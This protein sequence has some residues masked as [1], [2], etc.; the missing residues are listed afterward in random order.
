MATDVVKLIDRSG[1]HSK[2]AAGHNGKNGRFANIP[3]PGAPGVDI[4]VRLAYS[5]TY[6]NEV[7]V[8]ESHGSSFWTIAKDETMLLQTNGGNGGDGGRGENGEHGGPGT[9]GRDATSYRD[10][11]PGG[12]GGRGGDGGSGSNGADGGPGGNITVTVDNDD[13][14]LLL[15][16]SFRAKGGSGG[17]PGYHGAP[18]NGGPGGPG[19][20]IDGRIRIRVNNDGRDTLSTYQ[21]IYE[22][23]VLSFDITD[24]NQDGINEPGEHICVRNLLV[25]N[26]GL[27]PS[28]ATRSIHVQI[29]PTRYLEPVLSEPLQLPYGIGPGQ[30]VEVPGVLRALIRN[31]ADGEPVGSLSGV[32]DWVQLTGVFHE[33]LDRPI[34]GFCGQTPIHISYPLV[35]DPPIFLRSVAKGDRVNFSWTVRNESQ[36]TY[37][38]KTGRPCATMFGEIMP[39]QE[40]CF[41]LT[42][43]SQGLDQIDEIQPGST[44]N[45]EQE[46][47][48]NDK[49]VDFIYGHLKVDLQLCDP[50]TS[51]D[52]TVQEH[53]MQV[54]VSCPYQRTDNAGYLLV[55]NSETPSYA[56]LQTLGF[57]KNHLHAK[58]DVFNLSIYGS[59]YI[60]GSSD[61]V[62]SE[63]MGK[64]I[65]IFGNDYDHP[66]VGL[67][68]PWD[69]IDPWVATVLLKGGT[70]FHFPNVPDAALSKLQSWSKRVVFPAHRLRA[71]Q[72]TESV[73]D[74]N[75]LVRKLR[76][77]GVRPLEGSGLE[78]GASAGNGDMVHAFRVTKSR[79]DRR[80]EAASHVLAENMPLR[81]F[82]TAPD[83]TDANGEG[84]RERRVLVIEGVPR[85]ARLTATTAPF[86]ESTRSDQPTESVTDHDAF[87]LVSS[88]PFVVRARMLWN[89]VQ[90]DDD[91][92]IRCDALFAGVEAYAS[93]STKGDAEESP[94]V[95]RKTILSLTLSLQF[96]LCNE[97]Y[98]MM[99]TKSRFPD[100]VPTKKKLLQM[101]LLSHFFDSA[102][103]DDVRQIQDIKKAQPLVFVLGAIHAVSNPI[104]SWHSFKA[105][106]DFLN[107]HQGHLKSRVNHFI[108]GIIQR[109]CAPS[110]V[111]TV[112][113]H[114]MA[115]S[116]QVRQGIRSQPSE[117]H[118][119]FHWFGN[120]ELAELTGDE[121]GGG[122]VAG[123]WGWIDLLNSGK[124]GLALTGQACQQW[125]DYHET[126][127]KAQ[128]DVIE[129]SRKHIGS[130]VNPQH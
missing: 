125:V 122:T 128:A 102:P 60:R 64:S 110:I 55:V 103:R 66:G 129:A 10:G 36:K 96:D 74:T 25:K 12:P 87:L 112:K 88:L 91:Q 76:S 89:I 123:G 82:V 99:G 116:E 47:I 42:D 40:A 22:L 72:Q 50:Q 52:R 1:H 86:T 95:H 68:R 126:K 70:S 105:T 43:E 20:G 67:K 31:Q 13:T 17:Q 130:M 57:L 35:L 78:D 59:Y 120:R 34:P 23:Q 127:H 28:P 62:L 119:S 7:Q 27:M 3:T 90:H 109:N 121:S 93:P 49:V 77:A 108:F 94:T 104:S 113:S 56:I 106:L 97:I 41:L 16:L 83:S 39:D 8:F 92:A 46:F 58:V 73:V 18:G 32:D 54:Q 117:M 9:K 21:G 65:I 30:E 107:R 4:S 26:L 45:I 124:A 80:T 101:P 44:V 69:L 24:E 63:Y 33:R 11:E 19:G 15:P 85:T 111:G 38:Y 48:V 6:P 100:P 61:S 81:R 14:D 2:P 37:G 5:E 51:S 29:Q 114:V 53:H 98:L 75:D 115:R 118:K 84:H 79:L 71:D